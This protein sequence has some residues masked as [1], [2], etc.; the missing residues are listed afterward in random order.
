M[1]NDACFN[2]LEKAFSDFHGASVFLYRSVG[3]TNDEAKSFAKRNPENARAVFAAVSQSA[4]RGRLGRSFSSDVGGLYFSYLSHPA[5]S[6]SD[7]IMMTVYAAV[8]L[9]EVIEELTPLKPGIKWVNDVFVGGKKLAGILTEGQALPSG[10]LGYAVVG[11]GVNVLKRDFPPELSKIAT[12]IE[13][14]CG[15]KISIGELAVRLA[16]KLLAFEES[17]PE[18]FMEK[19]R[20]YSIVI[21]KR[22]TVYSAGGQ[23]DADVIS[24]DSKGALTV[25]DGSGEIKRLFTG[26]VSIKI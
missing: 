12:D 8:A 13:S 17:D 24:I 2:D 22:V 19:Y 10:E 25:M 3:S 15:I 26:E 16:E 5:I 4:G 7:A 18:S 9:C 23:Y 14:E 21:G 11:I 6:A 20:N 1:T